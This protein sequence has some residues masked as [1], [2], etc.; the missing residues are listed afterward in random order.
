M[1]DILR[2]GLTFLKKV[3]EKIKR[4]DI[5]KKISIS[6]SKNNEK[7][8]FLKKG[9]A[10]SYLFITLGTLIC[11]LGINIFYA[12]VNIVAGGISG[13]AIIFY[14]LIS[15]PMGLFMLI[16]NIPIFLIGIKFLGASFG[17]KTFYGTV[18]L[19]L[20][21]SLTDGIFV[22]TQNIMLCALFG[23][24]LLGFGLGII[25]LSGATSGGTDILAR[26][27]NKRFSFLD[28]GKW[29]FVVDFLIILSGGVA[30][31]NYELLLYGVIALF[32]TSYVIDVM[33]AGVDFAKIV[34]IISPKAE[35]IAQVIL[36]KLERGVTGIYSK[37][38][39]S[40]SDSMMIMCVVKKFEVARLKQIAKSIDPNS[41]IILTQAREV[42]GEGF[43]K[44]PEE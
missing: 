39:Y 14:K 28:M 1:R 18:M 42:A 7:K 15:F 17:A 44:Y 34:Y 8:R 10:K 24:A 6:C 26:L 13:L 19:S 20:F 40:G 21:M 32:V 37:G 33:I 4:C 30:F 23:G 3:I 29:L 12:P 27:A 38:M 35:K 22:I 31:H 9:S 16:I 11:A 5:I 41:F 2:K 25:F 36:T 43:K